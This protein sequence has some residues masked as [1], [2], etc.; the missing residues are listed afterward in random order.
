MKL[1]L[2]NLILRW[3]GISDHQERLLDLERHFVTKKN[4]VGDP[5]ETLAD[6]PVERRGELRKRKAAG[7]SWPQRRALLEATDGGRRAPVSD[8]MASTS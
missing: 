3:L 5:I 6:V 2:R 8:R 1:W 4:E 7:M